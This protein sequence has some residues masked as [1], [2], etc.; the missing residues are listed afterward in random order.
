MRNPESLGVCAQQ[1]E[2][3]QRMQK[4]MKES[5]GKAQLKFPQ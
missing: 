3:Q 1:S 2:K 5:S 4:E